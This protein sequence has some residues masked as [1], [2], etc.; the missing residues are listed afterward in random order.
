MLVERHSMKNPLLIERCFK[1]GKNAMNGV[2]LA[3]SRRSVG[4]RMTSSLLF[5]IGSWHD[6]RTLGAIITRP[7]PLSDP[8]CYTRKIKNVTLVT[9][10]L[11]REGAKGFIR[12]A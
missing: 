8:H 11:K 6:K 10:L 2:A 9:T 7:P 3:F 5:V 12:N 1:V 4:M